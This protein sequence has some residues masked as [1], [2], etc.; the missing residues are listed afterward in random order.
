MHSTATDRTLPYSLPNPLIISFQFLV[1]FYLIALDERR[2]DQLEDAADKVM[3][4]LK[5]AE[6]ELPH[7]ADEPE[8]ES[9][10]K[11]I[12]YEHVDAHALLA[13]ILENSLRISAQSIPKHR[14]CFDIVD[15]YSRYV[16][17]LVGD[18][19]DSIRKLCST[20]DNPSMRK[21]ETSPA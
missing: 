21:R 9:V 19:P 3:E 4:E 6:A 5:K 17:T 11:H 16:S 7:L 8:E 1:E 15:E 12:G 20:D 18:L 13:L 14:I 2:R 10:W